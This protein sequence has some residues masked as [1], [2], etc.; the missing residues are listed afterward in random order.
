MS[1]RLRPLRISD[2]AEARAAHE[3]LEADAFSF[4]LD[5]DPASPWAEYVQQREDHRRGI[6]VPPGRVPSTFLVAVCGEQ[7]VGRVSVRHELNEFLAHVGGH[8]GYAVRPRHRGRG[9][10]TEILRQAL[11][12]ARSQGVEDVLVTCDEPNA[13]SAAVIERVGGVLE[14]VRVDADGVRKRRYWVR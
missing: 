10:A 14:D 5:W 7:L 9:H 8:V 13:A 12:V 4:L 6:R 2:E 1:L 3:E 11:I